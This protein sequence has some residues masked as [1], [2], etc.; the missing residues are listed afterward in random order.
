MLLP[1]LSLLR[2]EPK[3]QEFHSMLTVAPLQRHQ[4]HIAT[5]LVLEDER[6]QDGTDVIFTDCLGGPNF[7]IILVCQVKLTIS[8]ETVGHMAIIKL[9]I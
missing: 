2:L 5:G 4:P 1:L 7:N 3:E 8:F 6:P 9:Q